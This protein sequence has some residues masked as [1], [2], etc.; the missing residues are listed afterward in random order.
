MNTPKV[1]SCTQFDVRYYLQCRDTSGNWRNYPHFPR[2]FKTTRSVLR[3]IKKTKKT[4][5]ALTEYQIIKQTRTIVVVTT[6]EL[7]VLNVNP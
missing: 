3:T 7:E 5:T 2:G 4:D 6:T 1:E